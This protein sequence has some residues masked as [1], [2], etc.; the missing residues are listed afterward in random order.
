M[1]KSELLSAIASKTKLTK[2][3]VNSVLNSY[4]EIVMDQAIQNKE[5]TVLNWGKIK[6]TK[7]A[8]RKGLNP[9]TK[10][11]ITIPARWVPRFAFSRT[12]KARIAEEVKG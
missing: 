6:I 3:Q 10:K 8:E 11:P 5:F 12:L 4:A 7:S 2:D 9:A 1:N